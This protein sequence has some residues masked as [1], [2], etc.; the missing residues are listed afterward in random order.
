MVQLHVGPQSAH[1]ELAVG[2]PHVSIV[3]EFK[4]H[5]GFPFST[6]QTN[7]AIFFQMMN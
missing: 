6:M 1:L 7:L 3:M 4:L 2:S 5:A